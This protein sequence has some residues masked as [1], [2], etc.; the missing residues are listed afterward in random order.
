MSKKQN[1]ID[2]KE[3]LSELTGDMMRKAHAR[4]TIH[5]TLLHIKYPTEEHPDFTIEF[6]DKIFIIPCSNQEV[7]LTLKEFQTCLNLKSL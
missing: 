2:I 6:T 3:F 4:H 5:G 1:Y 7:D